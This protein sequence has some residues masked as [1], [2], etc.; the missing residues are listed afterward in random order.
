MLGDWNCW[1]RKVG[2]VLQSG[3]TATKAALML[4][5]IILCIALLFDPAIASGAES[6]CSQPSHLSAAQLRWAALRKSR[7]DPA[8]NDENCR[9][10]GTNFFEAVMARHTASFC[11]NVLL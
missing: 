6:D 3:D 4:L 9:A 2:S 5:I 10:Y 8:H 11:R 7:V 1:K